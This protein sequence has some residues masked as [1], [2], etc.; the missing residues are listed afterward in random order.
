MRN[1]RTDHSRIRVLIVDD[2][3]SIR[4]SLSAYL[5]DHDFEVSSAASAEEALALM[6]YIPFQVGIIDL[7]LPGM[8]GDALILMAHQRTPA[9]R[10]IIHTGSS[11]YQLP[12][13]L[14]RIGIRREHLFLKPLQDLYFIVEAVDKLTVEEDPGNG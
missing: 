8:S 5:E 12:E 11:S 13:E 7:R 2:E 9:M 14:K 6:D 1:T 4:L 3:S 10:F